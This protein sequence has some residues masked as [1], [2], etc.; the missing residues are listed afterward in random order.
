[1][2]SLGVGTEVKIDGREGSPTQ[3]PYAFSSASKEFIP[4]NASLINIPSGIYT[5]MGEG[6]VDQKSRVNTKPGMRV[7]VLRKTYPYTRKNPR[8]YFI[9]LEDD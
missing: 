5:W 6:W 4:M 2:Q 1:M 3:L 9:L 7:A 8:Y